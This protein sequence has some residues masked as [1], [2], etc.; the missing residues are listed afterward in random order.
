MTI[1]SWIR[2][3]KINKK[4]KEHIFIYEEKGYV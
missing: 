3:V 2:L 4:S 1:N